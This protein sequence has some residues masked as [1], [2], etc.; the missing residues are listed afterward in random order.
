M[1]WSAPAALGDRVANTLPKY[2]GLDRDF[3]A[4]ADTLPWRSD[5]HL[6]KCVASFRGL[7]LLR[8]PFGETLLGFLRKNAASRA[9][10]SLNR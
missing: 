5:P 7:H 3:S 6:A 10:E 2:L 8:Q 4:L 1:A 9:K